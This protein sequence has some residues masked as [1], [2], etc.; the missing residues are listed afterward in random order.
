MSEEAYGREELEAVTL[1]IKSLRRCAYVV[2]GGPLR[3]GDRKGLITDVIEADLPDLAGW[4]AYVFGSPHAVDS[5]TRLLRRKG[6]APRRLHA[7]PF[8]YSSI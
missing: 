2:G 6:I 5:T 4:R 1:D 7:E 3:R 8:L